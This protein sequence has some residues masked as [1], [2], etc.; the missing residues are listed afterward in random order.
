MNRMEEPVLPNHRSQR[1]VS[2]PCGHRVYVMLDA[3]LIGL[4]GPVLDHQSN[5]RG[6]RTTTYA[7]WFVPGAFARAESAPIP[8]RAPG[9][10]DPTLQATNP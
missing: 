10:R 1:V 5:C 8:G 2:L 4:S 9:A 3:S 7:A 6:E